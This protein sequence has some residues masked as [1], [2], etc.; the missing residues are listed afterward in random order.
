MKNNPSFPVDAILLLGP[1]GAGKTPLGDFIALRGFLS[2]RAVHLD[3]GSELRSIVAVRGASVAYSPGELKFIH[4]VLE[5]GLL[6]ENEHFSLATKIIRLFLERARFSSR[7]VLVLN[8][9][10]RH[11]GQATDIASI[12]RVH[13]LV[14]LNCTPEAVF[15]RIQDNTGGDRTGREDDERVLIEKKMRIFQERTAP[16]IEHYERAG[17][18]VYRIEITGRTTTDAAYEKLSSLAAAN[19]PVSLITEPPQR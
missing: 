17:C 2:R 7:D 12:A 18:G 19:P 16:L 5:D 10:P 11:E 1:T 15:M 8:G 4:G 13:S 3:F 9:I 14:V 6:L